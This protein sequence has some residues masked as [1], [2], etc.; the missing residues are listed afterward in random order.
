MIEV[1]ALLLFYKLYYF[2]YIILARL[3]ASLISKIKVF[4]GVLADEGAK[5]LADDLGADGH[6]H[7]LSVI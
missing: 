5:L 4:E 7:I 2:F 3:V 1:I 6:V